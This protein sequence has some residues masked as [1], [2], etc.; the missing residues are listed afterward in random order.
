MRRTQCYE[1]L[2]TL[3]IIILNN[4]IKY[5]YNTRAKKEE[6]KQ[7]L[8]W[9]MDRQTKRNGYTMAVA[10]TKKFEKPVNPMEETWN[11]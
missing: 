7:K 8:E 10:F 5:K 3:V 4:I 11:T 2:N 1:F 9:N 6:E